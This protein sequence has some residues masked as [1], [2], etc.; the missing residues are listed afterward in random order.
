YFATAPLARTDPVAGIGVNPDFAGAVFAASAGGLTPPVK[1]AQ[2]FAL[3]KVDQ[4]VPPGPQPL[5]AI[6]DAVTTDYKQAQ[7]QQLAI[8]QAKALQQAAAKQGLKAAAAA[9]H[10]PVKTSAPVIRA[11]ALPDAG[12]ISSFADTLFALKPG[13]VAPV[14][15]LGDNQLV[16]SLVALQQPTEAEFATQRASVAQELLAQKQDA[17]F[18]AYTD[19]MLARLTKAGKIK[20]NQDVLQQV[21]G[22]SAPSSPAPPTPAPPSPLGLG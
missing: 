10:L 3:A 19:A 11:G 9:M 22:G 18:A 2:G 20:V 12:A 21:L 6:K 8:T 5:E 17:V 13:A 14:A 7:A 15:S 1:V 16:Y 4:I